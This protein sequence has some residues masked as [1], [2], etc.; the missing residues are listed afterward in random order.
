[1]TEQDEFFSRKHKQLLDMA[2]WAIWLAWVAIVIHILMSVGHYAQ[3]QVWYAY[4]GRFS[5]PSGFLDL[6]KDQPAIG[7]GIFI[8]II[9]ILLRGILYFL[10]LKGISLG[11]NMI[12]ETDINYREGGENEQ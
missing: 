6:L 3:E 9:G 12:V 5:G 4:F 1:M 11:L 7:F 8:E 10:V 2:T